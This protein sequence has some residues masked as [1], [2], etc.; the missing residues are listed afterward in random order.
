MTPFHEVVPET[1]RQA[2]P[3]TAED[4]AQTPQSVQSLVAALIARLQGLEAEVAQ[5][6]ER[7]NR[8]SRNSSQPPSS[9]GPGV[10]ERKGQAMQRS[11]RKRGGQPG[12]PGAQRKL[13]PIEQVK[14]GFDVK[15]STCRKCG[16]RLSGEDP[17]PDRH[18]VA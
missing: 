17:T 18:Q 9:D 7:V 14:E 8:N 12:H 13:V 10:A 11:G 6:H 15:P 3:V 4:W 2:V 16:G 5:L 1:L